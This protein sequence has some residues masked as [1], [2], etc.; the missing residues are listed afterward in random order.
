MPRINLLP[1]PNYSADVVGWTSLQGSTVSHLDFD[2]R[3]VAKV[4]KADLNNSGIVT[5]N[6]VLVSG[7]LPYAISGYVYVPTG[8][9]NGNFV[10]SVAWYSYNSGTQVYTEVGTLS[11]DVVAITAGSGWIRITQTGT[12]PSTATHAKFRVYQ[13]NIG[14]AGE[15]FYVDWVLLEQAE[16]VGSFIDVLSQGQ[17]T[18]IVNRALSQYRDLNYITGLQL[19]ADVSL[20]D[21]VLNTIDEDE[22]VWICSDIDGWWT[23][24]SPE[25]PDI[26]RG[27]EDGSYDVSGR[28]ASRNLTLTG[29]FIPKNPS[30]VGLARDKLLEAVNLVRKGAWLRTS[31]EPTK[32]SFVRLSGQPQIQ[33]MN[34]RGR[35]EFS[36]GLRAGDPIKYK[37]D[38]SK[39]DGITVQSIDLAD[40]SPAETATVTIENEGTASV[41]A[42]LVFTGPLGAGSTVDVYHTDDNTTETLTVIEALRGAGPVATVTYVEMTNNNVTLT[43]QEPHGLSVGEVVAI[44]GTSTGTSYQVNTASSGVTITAVTSTLPYTINYE[45]PGSNSDIEKIASGGAISLVS[46]DEMIVDTYNRNVTLNGDATGYRSKLDT[47][48]DFITLHPGSNTLTF[49]DSVDEKS[50]STKAYNPTTNV[51]TLT[52]TDSHFL[53]VSDNITVVIPEAATIAFKEITSD[54]ITITTKTAHGFSVGDEVEVSTTLSTSI[55]NKEI[56]ST[57]ATLTVSDPAAIS[58]GDTVLIEMA[59]SASV[60]SKRRV[61]D[62]V[63]LTTSSAHGFSSGD[64]V[65]VPFSVDSYVS[66]KALSSNF[67]TITTSTVHNFSTGDEVTITLPETAT[68]NSKQIL[69]SEV[70]LVTTANHGF[71]LGDV[72]TVTLP[73]SATPTGTKTLGGAMSFKPSARASSGTTRTITTP[74][75]HNFAIGDQVY[76]TS[77]ATA[78]DGTYPILGTPTTTTFTYTGTS[79]LTEL[80]SAMSGEGN[81]TNTSKSYRI[82][83]NTSSAHGCD[84][85]D[86]ITVNIGIADTASV[87]SQT[88]DANSCTLA[89]TVAHKYAVGETITVSGISARYN[90]THVLTAVGTDTLTYAFAGAVDSGSVAGSVINQTIRN[91]YNGTKVVDTVIDSDT[92]TYLYYGQ[93]SYTTNTNAGTSPTLANTTNASIDG[94]VTLTAVVGNTMKYTK[95]V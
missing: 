20:G 87:N 17:E 1:N 38:D 80:E 81:V 25:L 21:F 34:S 84:V 44:S 37:W 26:P 52:T 30:D 27:F 49:T 3:S 58:G 11:S 12:S 31:E 54:V 86:I 62:Q 77:V 92:L 5:S 72:V 8:E 28:Y 67:V 74:S 60:I 10:V 9:Q 18:E 55:T 85:G 14:T 57:T 76:V 32:A 42:N 19:N 65:T 51:V 95:V 88:A 41:T 82:F 70:T 69:G 46:A 36:I 33:T 7:S 75:A 22:V 90:G 68:V 71:S 48:T 64:L 13:G 53:K 2:G 4:I 83:L 94:N 78:Y 6:Y 89:T 59:S 50:V 43:T 79:S 35:T 61:D 66:K 63:T 56:S 29:I 16:Y 23:T 47:L 45:V 93:E 39:V 15:F 40:E 24:A 73:T 91:G